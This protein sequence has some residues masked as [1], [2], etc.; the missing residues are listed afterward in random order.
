MIFILFA[1]FLRHFISADNI[2]KILCTDI[3]LLR[4]DNKMDKFNERY[5]KEIENIKN[6]LNIYFYVYIFMNF[7]KHI[8]FLFYNEK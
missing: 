5:K 6:T 8:R 1:E 3:T 7:N 2:D 4:Y